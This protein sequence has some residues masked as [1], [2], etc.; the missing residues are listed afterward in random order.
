MKNK[1]LITI[2]LVTIFGACKPDHQPGYITATFPE[3]PVNMGDINSEFDDYNSASPVIGST[4]PLCFSSKRNSGGGNFDIIYKLLDVYMSRSS[5]KLTVA[6]SSSNN[7]LDVVIENA[8]L[9]DAMS[10]I[11]TSADELGPY[12]LSEGT[13]F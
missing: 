4:S 5:G 9:I 13:K 11:N 10:K 2:L 6:E 7:L 3:S 12:L 1:S 8:N